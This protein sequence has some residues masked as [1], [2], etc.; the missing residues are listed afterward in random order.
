MSNE[1]SSNLRIQ[2]YEPLENWSQNDGY[3]QLELRA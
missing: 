3:E 2:Y 1:N